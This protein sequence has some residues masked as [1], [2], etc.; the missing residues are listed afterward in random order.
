MTGQRKSASGFQP[1]GAF[2]STVQREFTG[3]ADP[4]EA[5]SA[6]RAIPCPADRDTW[7]RI[8]GSA[9][10]AGIDEDEVL[11]WCESGP[12]FNCIDARS[13]IRSLARRGH[14]G[15]SG[16]LFRLARDRGWRGEY[17]HAPRRPVQAVQPDALR[18]KLSDWGRKLWRECQPIGG[19]AAAYLTA[20]NCVLPPVD[21]ALRWHPK[22]KHPSGHVGPALV[23]L[24]TNALTREPIS[25]HRTWITATGK[26]DVQPARLYLAGHDLTDGVIRLW[27][28]EL[29]TYG[30]GIAEGIETAL[31]LAWGFTPVWAMLDA[32]H[33]SG[34]KPLPGIETLAIA[35]DNDPAGIKASRECSERWS[36]AGAD[37]I[38]T[39]QEV[40]DLNDVLEVAA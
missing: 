17:R 39:R 3:S 28:D 26:A 15:R 4:R 21:G 27:P 34:F 9:L 40:N 12:G 33:L 7:W 10:E 38:V 32:G 1:S 11:T 16:S 35:C 14:S 20:R 23:A 37:V 30:L 31:S 25:L 29:V 18:T 2:Q 6:L 24:V 13:T 22:L 36:A 19:I 8:V 5:Y